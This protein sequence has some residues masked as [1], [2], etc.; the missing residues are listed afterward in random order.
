[1]YSIIKLEMFKEKDKTFKFA[2]H[3]FTETSVIFS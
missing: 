1:M 2:K 3:V